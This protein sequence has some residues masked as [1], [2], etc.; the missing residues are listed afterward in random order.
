VAEVGVGGR[1]LC[2]MGANVVFDDGRDEQLE[3]GCVNDGMATSAE[4][5]GS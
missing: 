4:T 2:R 3:R 1:R 5:Q